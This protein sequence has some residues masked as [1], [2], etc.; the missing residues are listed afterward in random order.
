MAAPYRNA[1][2]ARRFGRPSGAVQVLWTSTQGSHPLS[3]TPPWAIFGSPSGRILLGSA[4]IQSA[5]A[6]IRVSFAHIC[7]SF[8]HMLVS[9][10]QLL[11]SFA[12]I[13]VSMDSS[14]KLGLITA[15]AAFRF[16]FWMR[17]GLRGIRSRWLLSAKRPNRRSIS[18]L[19]PIRS[20]PFIGSRLAAIETDRYLHEEGVEKAVMAGQ[21]KH[22]QIFS[23]IRPDWPSPNCS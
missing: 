19:R 16:C 10:T 18:A 13:R 2:W 14:M 8:A 4:N 23:S 11:V 5:F 21:V 7:V 17:R 3:R 9:F 22:K 15:M 20:S 12:Q 6:N 1:I